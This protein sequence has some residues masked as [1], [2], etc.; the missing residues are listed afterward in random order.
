MMVRDR[1]GLSYRRPH[2]QLMEGLV[3]GLP[4]SIAG[5]AIIGIAIRA[6]MG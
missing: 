4:I 5:W 6:A 2:C 3:V 1:T